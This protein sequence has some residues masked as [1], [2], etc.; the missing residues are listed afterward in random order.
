MR[1]SYLLGGGLMIVVAALVMN[2]LKASPSAPE[3][4]PDARIQRSPEPVLLP[5]G[6]SSGTPAELER[7]RAEIR[8]KDQLLRAMAAASVTPSGPTPSSDRMVTAPSLDP[9]ARTADMLDERLFLGAK[10]PAKAAEMERALRSI[11]D[12]AVLGEATLISLY[13]G[14]TLCRVTLKAGAEGIVNR[15][16]AAMSSHLPKLFGAS[17]AFRLGSGERALYVAQSSRDLAVNL[18]ADDAR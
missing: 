4:R 8:R 10:D 2:R 6:T 9:A 14:S 17:L 1:K 3:P 13:C 11:V 15:S 7:L 5:E 12:P 16:L 18:D